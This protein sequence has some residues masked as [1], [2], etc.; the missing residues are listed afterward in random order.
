MA[1]LGAKLGSSGK[2]FD[3]KVGTEFL[4]QKRH[5]L[6]SSCQNIENFSGR[7]KH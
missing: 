4:E 5:F 6:L 7:S 1:K 3:R 2:I